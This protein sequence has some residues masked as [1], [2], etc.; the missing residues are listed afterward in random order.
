MTIR[1]AAEEIFEVGWELHRF[2][3]QCQ[4][5]RDIT[6]FFMLTGM[7]EWASAC[8]GEYERRTTITGSKDS[9]IVAAKQVLREAAAKHLAA[10]VAEATGEMRETLEEIRTACPRYGNGLGSINAAALEAY[11]HCARIAAAALNQTAG[12]T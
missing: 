8:V 11:R 2:L 3:A 9:G 7:P 12:E 4:D 5:S 10:A 1:A 6:R